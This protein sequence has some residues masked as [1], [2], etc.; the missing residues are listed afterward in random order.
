MSGWGLT[1][2]TAQTFA[3]GRTRLLDAIPPLLWVPTIWK[4][5]TNDPARQ[6]NAQM[7]SWVFQGNPKAFQIDKYLKSRDT[8]NWTIRQRHLSDQLSVGDQV[9][10]WRSDGGKPKSGGIVAKGRILSL[11]QQMED[12]APEL[13]IGPPE[14]SVALRVEIELEDVRL[15]EQE[16]MLKRTDLVEDRRIRHMRILLVPNQ[17]NYRLEPEHAQHI[18][19]LWDLNG[20]NQR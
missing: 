3:Q 17:T 2:K 16:G 20:R 19:N 4:K 7:T 6:G 1:T 5:C 11:P 13:W 15:T 14:W 8:I 9:F 12:D 10:I 18:S